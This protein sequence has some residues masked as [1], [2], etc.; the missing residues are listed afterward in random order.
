MFEIAVV[1]KICTTIFVFLLCVAIL[2]FIEQNDHNNDL[3]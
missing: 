3:R 2:M 1:E